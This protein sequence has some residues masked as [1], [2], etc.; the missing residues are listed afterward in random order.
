MTN[1]WHEFLAEVKPPIV[2]IM[3]SMEDVFGCK[4]ASINTE[5]VWRYFTNDYGKYLDVPPELGAARWID[6]FRASLYTNCNRFAQ[7]YPH[8]TDP[9][10]YVEPPNEVYGTG[11]TV[12]IQKAVALEIALLHALAATGLPVRFVS[13]TAAVGNVNF[14]VEVELLR[15]LAV[16]AVA[17]G[18]PFGYHNYFN[19]IDGVSNLRSGWKYYAGRWTEIDAQLNVPGLLWCGMESGAYFDSNAGWRAP[20]C[21]NGNWQAYLTDL[22]DLDT[23]I[24]D[25][26][27]THSARYKG[28]VLF[29]SFDF[30]WE[31]FHIGTAELSSLKDAL[32]LKY[33]RT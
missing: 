15:R 23:L 4:D 5:V 8:H 16:E 7:L 32:K 28:C 3:S 22:L 27:A 30:G 26:N 10:F 2:K 19:T 6:N 11:D 18:S 1:G 14:G 12:G 25:W 33:H 29:T 21:Y 20:R 13:Y 17:H 31:A 24:N 9:Y